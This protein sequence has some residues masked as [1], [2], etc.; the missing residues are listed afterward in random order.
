MSSSTFQR[1]ETSRD[2]G[3]VDARDRTSAV[4]VIGPATV[5][6][7]RWIASLNRPEHGVVSFAALPS[8]ASLRGLQS[9]LL[10]SLGQPDGRVSRT[11]EDGALVATWLAAYGITDVVV[12]HADHHPVGAL[13]HLA[14][15]TALAGS[16]LWLVVDPSTAGWVV[17]SISAALGEIR[18]WESF[19]HWSS[20]PRGRVER[21]G[22][23]L[24][25][26]PRRCGLTSHLV[27]TQAHVD[28][29]FLTGYCAIANNA[30]ELRLFS[31]GVTRARSVLTAR[32]RICERL[33]RL[34]SLF[35]DAE[36]FH[37][38]LEGSALALRYVGWSLSL[39]THAADLA[40]GVIGGDEISELAERLRRFSNP[41]VTASAS[42]I[43]VG[44]TLREAADLV[45]RDV[46]FEATH[47][48]LDGN[49]V[50]IPL[51]LRKFVR[52]QR[53]ARFLDGDLPNGFLLNDGSRR[54]STR[55]IGVLARLGL[56]LAPQDA[57][58]KAVLAFPGKD[59]RWLRAIGL[60]LTRRGGR[61]RGSADSDRKLRAVAAEAV[62][63]PFAPASSRCGCLQPHGQP[64]LDDPRFGLTAPHPAGPSH[65]WRTPWR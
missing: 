42:L 9:E 22:G 15:T 55:S 49:R 27:S 16:R 6:A 29:V 23:T 47:V 13:A 48:V 36:C 3:E 40:H 39:D 64:K 8:S 57:T 52:A 28:S 20:T 63:R 30:R 5:Q 32:N 17:E 19:E 18:D 4:V 58:W 11:S 38:A 35:T 50:A 7:D 61:H 41:L 44:M 51:P 31:S 25:P 53:F 37:R 14:A 45:I 2:P 46:D 43:A 54:R 65:P 12:N 59:E 1:S 10:R 33:R 62:R 26:I 56:G 60:S 34:S 24:K 21:S